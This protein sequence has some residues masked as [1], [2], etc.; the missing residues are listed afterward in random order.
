MKAKLLNEGKKIFKKKERKRNRKSL[1]FEECLNMIFTSDSDPIKLNLK[2]IYDFRNDA[3]HLVIPFVPSDIM[4][5]FQA[6]VINF[7]KV[8]KNWFDINLSDRIPLGMMVLIYDFDPKQ[9]SLEYARFTRKLSTETINWLIEFQ[10]SV[11]EQARSIR[12]NS[13][14]YYIPID[15]KLAIVKNLNKADIVL[16]SGIKGKDALIVE[17][18]KDTDKIYPYRRKEITAD[19]NKKLNGKVVI[20][21]FDV[22]C[23]NI[24]HKTKN[25]SEY[26]YSPKF[27]SPQYSLSYAD[28]IVSKIIKNKDFVTNTRKKAKQLRHH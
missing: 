6:G 28:W 2:K 19:I 11:R 3:T 1:Y 4:G 22:D 15:F 12:N 9:H 14:Q 7:P 17:V 8:L 25:K 16:S 23:I 27:S 20:S 21:T 24:V 10:R 5:L 18:P 13:Q 26:I